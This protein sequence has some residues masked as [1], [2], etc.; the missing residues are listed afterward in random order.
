MWIVTGRINGERVELTTR[1][2]EGEEPPSLEQVRQSAADLPRAERLVRY[3]DAELRITSADRTVRSFDAVQQWSARAAAESREFSGLR[4]R[5]E[6]LA[7]A[8]AALGYYISPP[9]RHPG[10]PDSV[11][12]HAHSIVVVSVPEG[13]DQIELEYRPESRDAIRLEWFTSRFQTSAHVVETILDARTCRGTDS[14]LIDHFRKMRARGHGSFTSIRG[15]ADLLV[16][17]ILHRVTA[18]EPKP[19]EDPT[20]QPRLAAMQQQWPDVSRSCPDIASLSDAHEQDAAILLTRPRLNTNECRRGCP[21][22]P[23]VAG[24]IV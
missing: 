19:L 7:D 12:W 16:G 11:V 21:V 23:D 2:V 20:Y 14:G 5:F 15:T 8:D 17:R 3:V 18:A 10:H 4:G 6:S 9:A 24:G 1:V 13:V 22:G